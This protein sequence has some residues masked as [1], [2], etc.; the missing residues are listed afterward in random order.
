MIDAHLSSAARGVDVRLTVAA[1]ETLALIG[2]N[3]AGKSSVL[4]MIAGTLRPDPGALLEL[5]GHDLLPVPI[6]RR[7]V[8]LLGQDPLLFDHLD[9]AGNVAYGL[10][11]GGMDRRRAHAR[12]LE[13]LELVGIAD[14]AQR[15]PREVSGGQAQ[16]AALARALAPE[17]ELILLDEPLSALD[18]DVA[19]AIRGVLRPLLAGRTAIVVSHA[20]ADVTALADRVA[21]LESGR[22]TE[23]AATL[24]ELTGPFARSFA[25]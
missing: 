23:T 14:L 9:L 11:A 13:W 1:G 3:G 15:R 8:G 7:R 16:R 20:A 6:H 17:P 12:A 21:V 2:P 4:A 19:A 5:G 18:V 25:G 24:G 22:V 10:R